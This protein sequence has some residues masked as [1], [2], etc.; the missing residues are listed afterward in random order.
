MRVECGE[1]IAKADAEW[2]GKCLVLVQRLAAAEEDLKKPRW[3]RVDQTAVFF[4][5]ELVAGKK[6]SNRWPSWRINV[7]QNFRNG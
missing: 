4:K 7:S 3:V 5:G 6:M 1:V 2:R